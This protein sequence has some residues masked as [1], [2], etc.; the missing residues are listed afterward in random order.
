MLDE[1]LSLNAYKIMFYKSM[2]KLISKKKNDAI[3][4]FSLCLNST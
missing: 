1:I 4:I 3:N 2:H